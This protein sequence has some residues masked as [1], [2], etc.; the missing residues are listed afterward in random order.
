MVRRVYRWWRRP[1]GAR[2]VLQLA[3][4][5][6]VSS[7]SWTVMT[8]ID[9]MFLAQE[10]TEALA[11]SLPSVVL[12]WTL[13]CGPL[14]VCS[15]VNT[16]VAQLH[17]MRR[18]REI[19][20]AVWQG[21]WVALLSMP[22]LLAS[23]PVAGALF[24]WIGHEPEIVQQETAYFEVLCLG[25]GGLL[26]A[27]AL[28]A[29]YTGRGR[30]Q[31]VMLVEAAAAALN[32]LLDYLW[33]FGHA[34]FPA[35]GIVGAAWATV[36]AVWFKAAVY[37]GLFLLPA[38]ERRFCTR[39]GYPLRRRALGRLLWFG[40]PSGLQLF[41][42]VA[43]FNAF[44]L[45]L[46]RLGGLELAASSA[47]FNISNL[48][49]MPVLGLGTAVSTLVGQK[50]GANR[51]RLAARATCTGLQ[52]SLGYMAVISTLYVVVPEWFLFG[53]A[54]QARAEDA[55]TLQALA[56]VLLRFV[57]AYNT[58]D[59]INIILVAAL[60]GAGDTAFIFRASLAL[61]LLLASATYLA[62]ELLGWGVYRLWSIITAWLVLSA[63][64]FS[65]RY[66][67]GLWRQMR[68][69]EPSLPLSQPPP[70]QRQPQEAAF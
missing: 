64:V 33:I 63:A 15:Y 50:L 17:G 47:A 37:C 7:V 10:S 2:E 11:A 59:A 39:S 46:G 41:V 31:V 57:A 45:L 48:A 20:P 69:V 32:V 30:T 9:R 1:A 16:F 28:S 54:H 49:F 5:L 70:D 18:W 53:F 3:L 24:S 6:I 67:R 61:A 68:V 35:A 43:G 21:I 55:A 36:V 51:P 40:G 23:A 26:T 14:G 22:L 29:F 44:V 4:P 52:L 27:A 34:G 38:N 58:F 13:L 56:V 60:K 65:L 62:I 66:R 25:S 8:F 12:W 19:G 42:E